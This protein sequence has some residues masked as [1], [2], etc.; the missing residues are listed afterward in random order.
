[1]ESYFV[2]LSRKANKHNAG[3]WQT[4]R[5]TTQTKV[6]I[7]NPENFAP[8]GQKWEMESTVFNLYGWMYRG[9]QI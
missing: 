7:R 2:Y 4:C 3:I 9:Y 6:K 1:M 5:G 8:G